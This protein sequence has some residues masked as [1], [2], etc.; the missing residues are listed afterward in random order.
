MEISLLLSSLP[1]NCFR[2]NKHLHTIDAFWIQHICRQV[3]GRGA[4]PTVYPQVVD[5]VKALAAYNVEMAIASRTPSASVAKAFLEQLSIGHHFTT[6]VRWNRVSSFTGISCLDGWRIL[7]QICFNSLLHMLELLMYPVL[8]L[9]ITWHRDWS[10]LEPY[11]PFALSGKKI[12]NC[13]G[14]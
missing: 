1:S 3:S 7:V 5:I 8:F 10:Y 14:I 6:K 2:N 13:T 12:T 4:P 11:V 9:N